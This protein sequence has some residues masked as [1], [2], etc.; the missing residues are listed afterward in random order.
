[1]VADRSAPRRAAR[2]ASEQI[3]ADA[4]SRARAGCCSISTRAG[5]RHSARASSA[6]RPRDR[7]RESAHGPGPASRSL[8]ADHRRDNRRP[9]RCPTGRGD[10]HCR[11]PCRA[12]GRDRSG[13][14][15]RAGR[16]PRT[17]SPTSRAG[18]GRPPPTAPRARLR[19]YAREAHPPSFNRSSVHISASLLWRTRWRG[20]RQ[21]IACILPSSRE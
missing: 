15:R 14:V 19:Q 11:S 6:Y 13:S 3:V 21:P 16:R 7:R 10:C 12:A 20:G 4:V 2:R 18:P 5:R 8:R 9:P 1:M 17:A